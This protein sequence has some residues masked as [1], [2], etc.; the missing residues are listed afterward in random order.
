MEEPMPV[1]AL[2][3]HSERGLWPGFE[4]F[5]SF[6]GRPND[7]TMEGNDPAFKRSATARTVPLLSFL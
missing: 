1:Y 6:G 2:P 4:I 7:A 3:L 5:T